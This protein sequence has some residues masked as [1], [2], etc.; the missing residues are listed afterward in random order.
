MT[1]T[2]TVLVITSLPE[3]THLS[4]RTAMRGIAHTMLS[5]LVFGLALA[6]PYP[7]SNLGTALASPGAGG[8]DAAPAAPR[9]AFVRVGIT[10]ATGTVHGPYQITLAAGPAIS[11]P[12]RHG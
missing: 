12:I 8:L 2:I 3:H 4:S 11:P 5:A 1:P 10:D 6:S 9:D 7:H